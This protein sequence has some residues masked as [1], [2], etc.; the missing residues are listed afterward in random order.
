MF[1]VFI[2]GE[3]FSLRL[4]RNEYYFVPTKSI[5]MKFLQ[6]FVYRRLTQKIRIEKQVLI[7]RWEVSVTRRRL[8]SGNLLNYTTTSS[9]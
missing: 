4:E 1:L 8:L 3:E 6:Y 9:F 2:R 7:T 5:R